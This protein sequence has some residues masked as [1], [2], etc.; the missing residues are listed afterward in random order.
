[1]LFRSRRTRLIIFLVVAAAFYVLGLSNEV[2]DVASPPALSFHTAL[3]KVESIVAFAAVAAAMAWWLGPTRRLPLYLVAG[4]ACYSGLIEL[5][6]RLEASHEWIVESL[7]DVF[8]GAAGGYIVA[9]AMLFWGR[10]SNVD[11]K[12]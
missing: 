8:C 5:G 11:R 2:Y 10:R 6:Q 3:R 4:M 9:A 1:M 7:F 12:R